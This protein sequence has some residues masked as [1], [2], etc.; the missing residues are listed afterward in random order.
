MLGNITS[1]IWDVIMTGKRSPGKTEEIISK[2]MGIVGLRNY[3]PPCP[4][5]L[6]YSCLCQ[7]SCER[8]PPNSARSGRKQRQADS[9]CAVITLA[10]ALFIKSLKNV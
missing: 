2:K 1:Y 5:M 6:L 4:F 9:R 10:G 3:C 7:G 8:L